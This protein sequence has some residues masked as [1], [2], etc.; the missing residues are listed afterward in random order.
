MPDAAI[1]VWVVSALVAANIVVSVGIIRMDGLTPF[2]RVAQILIVWL[3]PVFGVAFVGS[4]W[5]NE[6][7]PRRP[8]DRTASPGEVSSGGH[9]AQP[10]DGG[11]GH[12]P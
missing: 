12:A 6:T 9:N 5:W 11:G 8:L 1:L 4:F 10:W 3:V 2:Q 7:H